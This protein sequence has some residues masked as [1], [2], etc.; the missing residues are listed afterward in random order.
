MGPLLDLLGNV[1]RLMRVVKS[2]HVLGLP[3][4][5]AA[6]QDFNST[7]GV[8]INGTVGWAPGAMFPNIKG[9]PGTAF[10]INIGTFASSNWLNIDGG[11]FANAVAG[12]AAGYRIARGQMTTATASDTVVTGLTTVVSA[13]ANLESAPVLTCD[14]AN[15]NIG[16]Q[17]GAPAAGSILITTWMPTSNSNP[18]P[19]AAT[20][21]SKL[22]NWIAVGT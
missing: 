1:G 19:I 4:G 17:S 21:F 22:V 3:V 7:T 16:N 5:K 13:V 11:V 15:G 20:T 12:V 8:P 2:G 9:G 14:R 10:Y 18:T 6:G